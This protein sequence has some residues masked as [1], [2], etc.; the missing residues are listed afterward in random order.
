LVDRAARHSTRALKSVVGDAPG[1][2]ARMKTAV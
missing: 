1:A 2:G